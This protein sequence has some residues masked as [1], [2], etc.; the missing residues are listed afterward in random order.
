MNKIGIQYGYWAK[1]LTFDFLDYIQ[2]SA[3]IGFSIF[4]CPIDTMLTMPYSELKKIKRKAEENNIE[5]TF[6]VGLT[7]EYDVSSKDKSI[8][9]KGIEY[10]KRCIRFVHKMN[11]TTIG[12][13]STGAWLTKMDEGDTDKR[14]YVER[15]V[16]SIKEIAKEAEDCNVIYALEV[17]NRFEQFII[18][19]AKEAVDFINMVN[20]PS[21]KI[22]LD[23][24][25]MN[26]EEDNI[27]EAI[28]IAG[29]K[30]GHFHISEN[31]RKLPGQA[32]IP[33]DEIFKALKRIDYK[34]H[35]VME[36]F[37]QSGGQVGRDLC[38]WS[39]VSP[40]NMDL[41]AKKSLDFVRNKIIF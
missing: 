12:G 20:N 10:L 21:I 30:L 14:P 37:V 16:K 33:W 4:E 36:P 3:N 34:S 35:I 5:L 23:T 40:K 25:H 7:G 24:F 17:V 18:N 38:I 29:D 31:N 13:V 15:S 2:R 27:G 1:E 9:E 19:T 39:D 28:I 41:A 22:L 6:C 32:H 11:G 8:R 26:I